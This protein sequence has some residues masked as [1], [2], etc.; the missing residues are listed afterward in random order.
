[1]K[2]KLFIRVWTIVILLLSL[3]VL[4]DWFQN[5]NNFYQANAA[6][7]SG[8]K[9]QLRIN[10]W[11]V[12][13][14]W[15]NWILNMWS[16]TAAFTNSTI[17]WTYTPVNS[18][19]CTD[20]MW[21][22]AW[23]MTIKLTWNLYSSAHPSTIATGNAWICYTG[24]L[25]NIQWVTASNLTTTISTCPTVSRLSGT[26]EM[27]KRATNGTWEIYRYWFTPRIWVDVPASQAPG[28]YTWVIEIGVP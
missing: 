25:V 11:A 7:N 3:V 21:S 8:S 15:W 28:I 20:T 1:M 18:W 23:T 17:S 6:W 9:V 19:E 13:C 24:G 10:E 16:V 4:M 12:T 5:N 2:N 22:W 26:L 27:M 14:T